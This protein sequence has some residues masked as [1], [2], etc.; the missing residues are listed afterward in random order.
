MTKFKGLNKNVNIGKYLLLQD[1]LYYVLFLLILLLQYKVICW[2]KINY[3]VNIC[4][5]LVFVI[6]EVRC[7]I[8]VTEEGDI[9]ESSKKCYSLAEFIMETLSLSIRCL[10]QAYVKVWLLLI[11]LLCIVYHVFVSDCYRIVFR[12]SKFYLHWWWTYY[13]SFKF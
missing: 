12:T 7:H 5:S 3:F 1:F 13:C 6:P 2:D 10:H 9:L 11:I 8:L 4:R